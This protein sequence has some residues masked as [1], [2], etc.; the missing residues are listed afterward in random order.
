MKFSFG[1]LLRRGS[2]EV[3]ASGGDNRLAQELVDCGIAAETSGDT[4]EALR[5]FRKAVGADVGF[6]PAHMNLGIALH[7][8]RQSA[9]RGKV[10]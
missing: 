5:C 2:A 3:L 1:N 7:A 9:I 6:A 4:V 8:A 10:N